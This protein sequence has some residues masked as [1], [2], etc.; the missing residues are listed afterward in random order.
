MSQLIDVAA[1]AIFN[2]R[3]ELLIAKRAAHRHQGNLWEFPGG[4]L[5]PDET[6]AQALSREL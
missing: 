4:K 3:D 1:A 6:A 5:E 2:D